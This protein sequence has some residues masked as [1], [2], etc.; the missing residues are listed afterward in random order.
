M[1]DSPY[2]SLPYLQV[3][4]PAVIVGFEERNTR[5]AVEGMARSGR[6]LEVKETRNSGNDIMQR[7]AE[8]GAL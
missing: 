6:R 5:E 4:S 7:G 1:N 8:S 3:I 2:V